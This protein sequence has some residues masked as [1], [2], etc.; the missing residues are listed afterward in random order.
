[1]TTFV[2]IQS[3]SHMTKHISKCL[4]AILIALTACTPKLTD[5]EAICENINDS[6][7]IIKWEVWPDVHGHVDIYASTDPKKFDLESQPIARCK[8]S[9]KICDI[10]VDKTPQARYYFLLQFNNRY[11]YIVATRAPRIKNICNL[12]DLGGYKNEQ[13]KVVKWG[14]LFRSGCIHNVDSTGTKKLNSLGIRT[15]IDFND[16][17]RFSIPDSGLKIGQI[18]HLPI[19]LITTSHIY[20]RLKNETLR[21]GD[22]NIFLQDLFITLIDSG[23]PLYREM[24]DI[25]LDEDNYPV[26]LSDKFGKDYVGFA[27]AL[28]LS[29]LN[30][31]EETIY[32]DFILSNQ[33]LD[34]R[35]ISFDCAECST[36]TQEAATALM[37][38]RKR[39]LFCAIRRIK[40]R[41]GSLQQYLR[42]E[43]DLTPEKQEKLQNILL[44]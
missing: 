9:D 29:A 30:I 35:A 15:L 7:Y 22:A 10:N 27:S 17:S 2:L 37:T 36:D 43:M 3:E 11:N 39:Q 12:R 44:Y 13:K 5:I 26:I 38:V 4:L 40:Q 41:Y 23:K 25:L 24:F 14:F 18:K 42:E 16:H 19:N 6:H 20:E 34:R 31:P 8:I 1:M 32:D 21:R 28:I 33:Y